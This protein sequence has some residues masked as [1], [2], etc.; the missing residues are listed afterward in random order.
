MVPIRLTVC[1]CCVLVAHGCVRAGTD[2]EDAAGDVAPVGDGAPDVAG[3]ALSLGS[4]VSGAQLLY[5]FNEGGGTTVKDHGSESPLDLTID[6]A[7]AVTWLPGALKVSSS[8]VISSATPPM[9][10]YTP[11]TASDAFT[12]EAW[13]APQTL[14]PPAAHSPARIVSYGSGFDF[15]NMLLGQ[16]KCSSS[17][18]ARYCGRVLLDEAL[19]VETAA[20]AVQ[21]SAL[22]HLALVYES[23]KATLYLNG[24]ASSNPV[25]GSGSL[26]AWRPTEVITVANENDGKRPWVGTLH[27]VACY[28]RPLTPAEVQQNHAAGADPEL[29]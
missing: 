14:T 3:D 13:V 27:L 22:T 17:F 8:V 25:S 29:P 6:N 20:N 26:S 9:K 18:E 11:C 5:L 12:L 21:L 16:G 1:C 24:L 2:A 28:C 4:R 15:Q 10:V 23:G 19:E 7:D